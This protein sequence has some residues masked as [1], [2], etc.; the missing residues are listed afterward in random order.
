M[1]AM[2]LPF[3]VMARAPC[4]R[5]SASSQNKMR[6]HPERAGLIVRGDQ[7][8]VRCGS[9]EPIL[10]IVPSDDEL[11]FDASV[12]PQHID[13]VAPGQEVLVRLS[14]LDGQESPELAGRVEIVSADRLT[15][16]DGTLAYFVDKPR[17]C[18]RRDLL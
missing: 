1:I 2:G 14:G 5:A 10:D 9:S 16:A 13:K 4:F 15:S 17:S 3:A 12:E 18:I 6:R 8:E 11:V 7:S